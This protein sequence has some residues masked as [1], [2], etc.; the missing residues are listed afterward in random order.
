MPK[1][2]CCTYSSHTLI[3]VENTIEK[4]ILDKLHQLEMKDWIYM[5]FD[6]KNLLINDPYASP[7]DIQSNKSIRRLTTS[8]MDLSKQSSV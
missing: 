6:A 1:L 2:A 7:R 8:G 3:R 4:S 5:I